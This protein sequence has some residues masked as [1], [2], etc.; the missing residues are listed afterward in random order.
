MLNFRH[1]GLTLL[2]LLIIMIAIGVLAVIAFTQYRNM[3]ERARYAEALTIMDKIRKAEWM[4]YQKYDVFSGDEEDL[5]IEPALIGSFDAKC[6]PVSWFSFEIQDTDSGDFSV[7]ARRCV[8]TLT[9]A[10]TSKSPVLP[11][12]RGYGIKMYSNSTL[13][14]VYYCDNCPVRLPV[15]P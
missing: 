3:S 15:V 4:Y 1:K 5:M 10:D 2:E 14:C 11:E 6:S 8:N 12:D 7:L 13:V 9:G